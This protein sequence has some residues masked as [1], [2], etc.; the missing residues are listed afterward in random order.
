MALMRILFLIAVTFPGAAAMSQKLELLHS[1][2][3]I[4]LRGLSAVNDKIVWVSG[5]KGMVGRS[6]NGGA[7]WSWLHVPGYASRDFRDIEAFDKNT[8]VI[9]AVGEPAVIL[10]TTDAGVRWKEVY[11][12][13]T[14]GMFLDAMEFWNEQSGI[15]VGDPIDGRFFVARTFDGGF[16]WRVLTADKLPSA[17]S[18]E[19]CFAASGTNVRA[20]TRG[21]ACF[22]SGGAVSRFFWREDPVSLPIAQGAETQGANSVAVW[23]K[24]RKTPLI[25]VVGGDFA[26]DTATSGNCVISRDGGRTWIKPYSVPNGYRSCVEFVSEDRLVTCGTSGVDVSMDGGLNWN[27]IS[28]EGFHVCRKSKKGKTVFLAGSDGKIG[29]VIW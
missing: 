28:P 5:N 19:A 7:T 4:S 11:R 8:A 20:L 12:N 9:M 6:V 1:E 25:A 16:T 2:A 27:S 24:K 17:K 29:R 21:E 18:G 22:V 23:Y 3:G 14:P 10:K 13:E 15:V 26:K